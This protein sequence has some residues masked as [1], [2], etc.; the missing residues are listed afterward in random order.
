MSSENHYPHK[1]KVLGAVGTGVFLATVDGSIVNVS[2]P[3]MVKSLQT[4]FTLIQWVVLSYLLS[5]T[6]LLLGFGRL[7]DI[8]GKKKIYQ[9]GFLVF[10]IASVCCGFSHTVQ[11]LILFRVLQGIGGAMIMALGPA[12]VTQA[13]PPTERGKALGTIG[14]IV[15]IGIVVGPAL[16]G[17][18]LQILSW[19]WIFYVNLPFGIVGLL[20]VGKF[21]PSM[22][23]G[24]RQPFDVLGAITLFITLLSL[25]VGL[26]LSQQF[27]FG[28]SKVVSLLCLALISLM[29]FTVI[30]KRTEHP[31]IHLSLFHNP[32]LT[33]NLVTS[34]ISF[35]ALGG[36]FI[37]IP[38]YLETILG[39]SSIKVGLLM[40][41]IPIMMGIF[42]PL[43]GNLADKIGSRPM[44]ITGLVILSL[45]YL[46]ASLLK[47][48]G[49]PLAFIIHI[50]SIGIGTGIFLSPNNSSIM[51]ASPKQHLGV[52][53]SL[54]ALSRTLGQ[55]VGIS[56]ISTLW[57]LHIH[58]L[59]G[60]FGHSDV[61]TASI[62]L[63]MSGLQFV[64]VI[65][66]LLVMLG[67]GLSIYGYVIEKRQ[68]QVKLS[69]ERSI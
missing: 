2:L 48:D 63:Q 53:S 29:L 61:S 23:P 20:M 10:T 46:F 22:T 5:V 14:L 62:P 67:L 64:F 8:F 66:S 34:F 68:Q 49:T 1:W 31:M 36:I 27:G 3:T 55:T 30:E 47:S 6:T 7:A 45:G 56:V 39:L 44:I 59:A 12:I 40:S 13:F 38:F 37:L 35:F 28:N 16:G 60:D 9:S 51:G 11:Q 43:S 15:S 19:N 32:L 65:V 69:E 57:A 42:S 33:V 24:H 50:V 41:V 52:V 58:H 18:I 4:N 17:F 25:L 21:I 54:M 26:S